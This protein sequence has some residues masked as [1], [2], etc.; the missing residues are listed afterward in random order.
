VRAEL[1]AKAASLETAENALAGVQ[2]E[3][4][5]MNVGFHESSVTADTQRVELVALRAQTEVLKG[6]IESYEAET[7]ELQARLGRRSA[8]VETLTRQLGEERGRAEH[9]AYQV[10]ELDRRL[11]AQTTESEILDRRVEELTARLDEQ[12]RFL[13]DREYVSDRLR[14]EAVAAHRTESD[15]R[16]ELAEAESRH[17]DATEALR[18][19][20]ALID[21]QL[22]QSLEER[23]RLQSEIAGMKRD[24]EGSWANERMENAVLRERINDV[25]AEVARLTATLEGPDSPIE[26]I[27]AGSHDAQGG[28]GSNG[29]GIAS[30]APA[31]GEAKG[32]LADRI[33]ALQGRASRVSQPSGA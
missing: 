1:A 26:A 8:E 27:L 18:A 16:A 32:T 12:G 3:L 30:I 10:S 5:H 2:A 24:A 17:R 19:E 4:G 29:N 11:M 28:P 14:N 33:R 20:K 21:D 23:A 6:Q 9:L 15:I 25:A 22:K 7:K 31:G 13:A